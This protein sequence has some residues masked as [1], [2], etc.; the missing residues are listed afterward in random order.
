MGRW[1][2]LGARTK[3]AH[4]ARADARAGARP[5]AW[6]RSAAATGALL[7]ELAQA[8]PAGD[9]ST[10]SSSPRRRS[11]SPA[12]A[13]S[14]APGRL[15]AYDG[16]R[17]PAE[18]GAY[19]L[20]VLS[21]VLE[22]VPDP[23][24]LL[25]E[26]A[27]V[28]ARVLVEV[29]LEDNRSGRAAAPSGPRPRGSATCTRSSRDDVRALVAAAG[30]E[31]R[32]ASSATRSPR[33]PRVLR[34]GRRRRGRKRGAEVGRAQRP[35]GRSRPK[36]GEKFFTVHYA[37][38]DGTVPPKWDL[39]PRTRRGDRQDCP[40]RQETAATRS[41]LLASPSPPSPPRPPRHPDRPRPGHEP[42]RRRRPRRH[43]AHPLP[44]RAP[45]RRQYCRLPR[46]AVA[47]DVRT[48]AAADRDR[49][50][51]RRPGSCGATSDGVLIRST[52]RPT[53]HA[54]ARVSRPTA[55][56]AS[57]PRGRERRRGRPRRDA[58]RSPP[59]GSPCSRGTPVS[60]ARHGIL[61][62]ARAFG[63]PDL[64]VHVPPGRLRTRRR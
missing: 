64:A 48:R 7:L 50:R 52:P 25:R 14:R 56:P 22:H 33:P 59:T 3:A 43:R 17:V 61:L 23:A 16:E 29:P 30:P 26:A 51:A 44:A 4:A 40:R 9:A 38:A 28:A 46:G 39:R 60:R 13:A 2:A 32:S 11:R 5:R 12:G 37:V 21:H 42:E 34:R 49:R 47:C 53:N 41:L 20:A 24:P 36:G 35:C 18:D 1:R 55:A 8:W 19:D 27:R 58:R 62:A 63:A 10:A 57:C 54:V 31:G 6:S 45:G 15:E